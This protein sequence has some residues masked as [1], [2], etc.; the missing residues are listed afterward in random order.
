MWIDAGQLVTEP[1][2]ES[3]TKAL[4]SSEAKLSENDEAVHLNVLDAVAAFVAGVTENEVKGIVGLV[5]VVAG[6]ATHHQLSAI[7]VKEL[8]SVHGRV[9]Y[10]E[11]GRSPLPL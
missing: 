11:K 1:L 10:W 5:H 6:P 7:V 4:S 2:S 8:K 3:S 9:R